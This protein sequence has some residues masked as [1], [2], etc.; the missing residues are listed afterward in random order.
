MRYLFKLLVV[1]LIA[2]YGW[3]FYQ[4][5]PDFIARYLPN[6]NT[7]A[8][9]E[10][11]G[12]EPVPDAV[13]KKGSDAVSTPSVAPAAPTPRPAPKFVSKIVVPKTAEG[14][15]PMTVPGELLVL[16]RTSVETKDGVIAVVPGD[17]VKIVERKGDGTVKV[18]DGTLDF[19][20]KDSQVTRDVELAQEAERREFEKKYHLR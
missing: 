19:V 12:D 1:A 7:P 10:P 5:N 6:K 16:E 17:T 15:R 8:P 4:N 11:S 9:T 13:V 2:Y 18:T 3:K 20:L 14:E